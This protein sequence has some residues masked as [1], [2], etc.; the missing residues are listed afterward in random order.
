MLSHQTQ[1]RRRRARTGW[2][3]SSTRSSSTNTAA[4]GSST[5]AFSG[6]PPSSSA[7]AHLP[8][9]RL[10]SC[11]VSPSIA[12]PVS[13]VLTPV[14]SLSLPLLYVPP[15]PGIIRE[16]LQG[17]PTTCPIGDS[18]ASP[19]LNLGLWVASP[20]TTVANL[21]HARRVPAERFLA[22]TRVV[23]LPGFTTTVREELAAL[24]AV[25]GP[26]ALALV[27]FEDDPVNRRV[28]ASWPARF[29]CAYARGLGF[30]ADEG[31][32]EPIVRR[33]QQQLQAGKV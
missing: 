12:L 3:S 8:Q 7:Q 1:L 6:F 17:L 32:M 25:A 24:A 33:F 5:A 20:E 16:P 28:V 29:D 9:R 23:C 27:R 15:S 21:V 4:A 10:P 18:L 2:A 26:D 19:A 13:L 31:G 22:H 11:P 14:F 30:V